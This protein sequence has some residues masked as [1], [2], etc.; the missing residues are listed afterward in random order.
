MHIVGEHHDAARRIHDVVVELLGEPI[1][2]LQR[3]VVNAGALVIEIVGADDGGVAAGVAAAEPALFQHRDIG[4]AVHRGEIIGGGQAMPAGADD[5]DVVFLLG[6][7]RG[8][9]FLPALMAAHGLAGDGEYRIF[10]QRSSLAPT[11]LADC[12][13]AFVRPGAR[14][15][16]LAK[17]RFHPCAV[18][19]GACRFA[20]WRKR[21]M[22]AGCHGCVRSHCLSRDSGGRI[23]AMR[24][25][26]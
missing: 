14:G 22:Q 13:R 19:D 24:G 6:L 25:G 8:P 17:Q 7:G 5:D 2:Q 1:P 9:L 18:C 20:P 15:V 3:M 23:W 11:D 4:D 12:R 10:L 21:P 16:S 26:I